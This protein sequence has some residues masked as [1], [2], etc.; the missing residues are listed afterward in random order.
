MT[1]DE[2]MAATIEAWLEVTLKAKLG[3][4]SF[5]REAEHLTDTILTE[6]STAGFSIEPIPEPG[7]PIMEKRWW[8]RFRG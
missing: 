1:P 8:N 5:H 3:L 6:L 7:A 2:V 4:A